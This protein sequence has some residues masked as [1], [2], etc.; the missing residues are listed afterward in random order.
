MRFKFAFSIIRSFSILLIF[1]FVPKLMAQQPTELLNIIKQEED[2]LYFSILD[3]YI[4]IIKERFNNIPLEEPRNKVFDNGK[5]TIGKD[6]NIIEVLRNKISFDQGFDA[7]T[8]YVME[9]KIKVSNLHFSPKEDKFDVTVDGKK[10][11]NFELPY[12]N[13]LFEKRNTRGNVIKSRVPLSNPKAFKGKDF[14]LKWTPDNCISDENAQRAKDYLIY[15]I[16]NQGLKTIKSTI[17]QYSKG[18]HKRLALNLT[19]FYAIQLNNKVGPELRLFANLLAGRLTWELSSNDINYLKNSSAPEQLKSKLFLHHSISNFLFKYSRLSPQ[20]RAVFFEEHKDWALNQKNQSLINELTPKYGV[21]LGAYIGKKVKNKINKEWSHKSILEESEL[22]EY[23]GKSDYHK[24][25]NNLVINNKTNTKV[26]KELMKAAMLGNDAAL[27]ATMSNYN[28]EEFSKI[29]E[30]TFLSNMLLLKL[31]TYEIMRGQYFDVINGFWGGQSGGFVDSKKEYLPC[32]KKVTILENIPYKFT[33]YASQEIVKM[34]LSERAA[35]TAMIS[36]K[37]DVKEDIFEASWNTITA[38][39]IKAMPYNASP[40]EVKK[41]REHNKQVQKEN[42]KQIVN[43]LSIF[44]SGLQGKEINDNLLEV[45]RV[46]KSSLSS[47]IDPAIAN[48]YLKEYGRHCNKYYAYKT[49]DKWFEQEYLNLTDRIYSSENESYYF[50]H[51]RILDAYRLLL[52]SNEK[53]RF[54]KNF[55]GKSVN[56][57][58]YFIF[59]FLLKRGLSPDE[60]NEFGITARQKLYKEGDGFIQDKMKKLLMEYDKNPKVFIDNSLKDDISDVLGI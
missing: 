33:K 5:F 49:Y 48:I 35:A 1:C 51:N 39:R 60:P 26:K 20:D 50:D 59:K 53:I 11:F 12:S 14:M 44:A 23:I 24:V 46:F 28:V 17:K 37:G 10:S 32:R 36:L 47:K 45:E 3:E 19:N 6:C 7:H 55:L 21:L 25:L 4:E 58:R 29:E 57:G 40:K 9:K 34:L 56:T 15:I 2:K 38:P 31:R 41:I 54:H 18:E 42:F 52:D 22:Y 30:R 16:A 8:Q 13:L 43:G 27:E